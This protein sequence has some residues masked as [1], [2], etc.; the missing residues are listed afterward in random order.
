VQWH[1]ESMFLLAL[2]DLIISLLYVYVKFLLQDS[3]E[4]ENKKNK[5]M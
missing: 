2:H 5:N 4:Q 3:V 1:H